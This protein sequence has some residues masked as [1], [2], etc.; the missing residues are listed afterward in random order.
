MHVTGAAREVSRALVDGTGLTPHEIA[1]LATVAAAATAALVTLR[2]YDYL[3]DAR[4]APAR[5]R[6]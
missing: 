4:P 6:R 2:V 1:A 3:H 5:V